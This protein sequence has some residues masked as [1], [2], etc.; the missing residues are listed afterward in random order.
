MKQPGFLVNSKEIWYF[1]K[2]M[3]SKKPTP[4]TKRKTS[5]SLT[6]I[7]KKGIGPE[8]FQSIAELGNDGILVFNEHHQIEYANRMASEITGYSNK[9]LLR[10]SIL[11]LLEEPNH[12]FIKD[13]FTH[14]DRYGEKTCTSPYL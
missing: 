8:V 1:G 3:T 4:S 13:F 11:S 12:S 10:M 7:K 14:P 2:G 5:H 6:L 9:E